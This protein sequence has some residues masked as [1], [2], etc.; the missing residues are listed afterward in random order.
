[1][2][3]PLLNLKLLYFLY[4]AAKSCF[5]VLLPVFFQANGLSESQIGILFA[6]R[7]FISCW[8]SPFLSALA[9]SFHLH[10]IMLLCALCLSFLVRYL[11]LVSPEFH[12]TIIWIVITSIVDAPIEPIIDTFVMRQLDDVTDFGRVR[13]WAASGFGIFSLITG[14]VVSETSLGWDGMFGL[15]WLCMLFTL[16][17]SFFVVKE[18][19]K[20]CNKLYSK[21][22]EDFEETYENPEV[23]RE[24]F[25]KAVIPQFDEERNETDTKKMQDSIESVSED[26]F[27]TNALCEENYDAPI[28]NF[29]A[30]TFSPTQTVEKAASISQE[31]LKIVKVPKNIMFFFILFIGGCSQG[32]I[33]CFLYIHLKNLGC[34]EALMGLARGV[35][36]VAAVLCFRYA[37]FFIKL[38]GEYGVLGLA[39]LAFIVRFMY[40]T[41]LQFLPLWAILPA[42]TLHGFTHSTL[43]ASS[44]S[45]AFKIAPS[46]L[47]TTLQGII[48]GLHGGVGFGSGA[49]VGG[50]IF[51]AY[52]AEIL[53]RFGAIT[54]GMALFFFILEKGT[55]RVKIP[56]LKKCCSAK[57]VELNEGVV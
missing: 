55:V 49:L 16:F 28:S 37:S 42:E 46:H 21:V 18:K 48:I 10:S 2:Q 6:L 23:E 41:L 14:F 20:C 30:L 17:S 5:V 3:V 7:P 9:D 54:V 15:Y 50:Y 19:L 25:K 35:T 11:F 26:N 53:F 22:T 24:L 45:I 43:W 13:V 32:I 57:G 33:E 52:G 44:T 29:P 51:E 27:I 4:Y 38:F 39:L 1:M 40:F 31:L 56:F 36:G 47:K 34:N 8:A 12:Y